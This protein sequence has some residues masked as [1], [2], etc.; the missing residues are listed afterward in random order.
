[1]PGT[2]SPQQLRLIKMIE[3][4]MTTFANALVVIYKM[5]SELVARIFMETN[6]MDDRNDRIVNTCL[7][8]YLITVHGFCLDELENIS[9]EE[10]NRHVQRFVMFSNNLGR[11][12]NLSPKDMGYNT[13]MDWTDFDQMVI[14]SHVCSNK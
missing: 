13:N 14:K 1:M 4:N 9:E 11:Q 3:V 8:F 2:L 6:S 5:P 12:L 10:H 7:D